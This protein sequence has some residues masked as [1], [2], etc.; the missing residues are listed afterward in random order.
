MKQFYG[1][2]VLVTGAASGI[3]RLM[4]INFAQRG[5]DVLVVDINLVGAEKVVAEIKEQGRDA[6]AYAV[7]LAN[8]D[9]IKQLRQQIKA[10]QGRI[11]VL[12]NNAGV[13]FGGVFE[14]VP[15][16]RHLQTYAV[17]TLGLMAI[18]HA[19]FTDILE[20]AEG[21]IVNIASAYGYVGLPYGATYAS[22]KWAVIGLSDSIR[23]ELAERGFEQVGVTTVC[24]GYITTGMFEGIKPP[25]LVPFLTPEKI[26][27]KIMEGIE[28]NLPFVKEPF[29][30][31]SVDLLKATLSQRLWDKAA[32]ALGV[33]SS[34][35]H[36][37]GKGR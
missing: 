7:D 30:V 23:L 6:H 26:V 18:T 34:M 16:E 19:F 3:G 27:A 22:S 28:Q 32:H 31:R 5:A 13:V 25:I 11:D 36:W 1:K 2:K 15:L 33:S 17:N 9:S 21:H 24:P 4:A 10:E 29:M 8:I 35:M 20:S 12:V 37:R 14:M